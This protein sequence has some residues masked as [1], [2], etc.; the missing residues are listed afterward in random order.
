MKCSCD[1]FLM[2]SRKDKVAPSV[3]MSQRDSVRKRHREESTSTTDEGLSQR[4]RGNEENEPP[5]SHGPTAATCD[6]VKQSLTFGSTFDAVTPPGTSLLSLLPVLSKAWSSQAQCPDRGDQVL[7]LSTTSGRGNF[8]MSIDDIVSTQRET[9]VANAVSV[10]HS[11]PVEPH[12]DLGPPTNTDSSLMMLAADH[13]DQQCANPEDVVPTWFLDVSLIA[14]GLLRGD[15]GDC[16]IEVR[17]FGH[18][19]SMEPA[20]CH[21]IIDQLFDGTLSGEKLM[22][23]L[24]VFFLVRGCSLYEIHSMDS[25]KSRKQSK[26]VLPPLP[27]LAA[28]LSSDLVKKYIVNGSLLFDLL[29]AVL[30]AGCVAP[31]KV[32]DLG[33]VYALCCPRDAPFEQFP[34]T[35]QVMTSS[36]SDDVYG[37]IN[38]LVN[39]KVERWATSGNLDERRH[40]VVERCLRVTRSFYL[41]QLKD[42]VSTLRRFLPQRLLGPDHKLIDRSCEVPD[43]IELDNTMNVVCS[44]MK[45]HGLCVDLEQY[46]SFCSVLMAQCKALRSFVNKTVNVW[47]GND[48]SLVETSVMALCDVL[49]ERFGS[50]VV[51][52]ASWGAYQTKQGNSERFSKAQS[53]ALLEEVAMHVATR[54]IQVDSEPNDRFLEVAQVIFVF[55]IIEEIDAFRRRGDRFVARCSRDNRFACIPDQPPIFTVRP[56]WQHHVSGTGRVFSVGCNV[57]TLSRKDSAV[58]GWKHCPRNPLEKTPLLPGDVVAQL[59][60]TF[61]S[62]R[63]LVVAP[64]KCTFMS[65]D[66]CQIELRILA[67]LS[68]DERLR[69][70]FTV[71]PSSDVFIL[72][73]TTLV[74]WSSEFSFTFDINT[75]APS[76]R[77]ALR[78][79]AKTLVYSILFGRGAE[80]VARELQVSEASKYICLSADTSAA[81]PV[82]DSGSVALRIA[83]CIVTAFSRV[84][85]QA[86]DFLQSTMVTASTHWYVDGIYRRRMLARVPA[87]VLA[88]SGKKGEVERA[89]LSRA[90]QGSA[91]DIM[92]LA[93]WKIQRGCDALRSASLPAAAQQGPS[94]PDDADLA[95]PQHLRLVVTV[96]DELIFAVSSELNPEAMIDLQKWVVQQMLWAGEVLGMTNSSVPLRVTCRWRPSLCD[97][98]P[99]GTDGSHIE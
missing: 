29:H 6:T 49:R 52:D 95:S 31:R 28:L 1:F 41:G 90:I 5:L 92:K 13:E 11:I 97:E 26:D 20:R 38:K 3:T 42:E 53:L 62:L 63:R 88:S 58:L 43:V 96:H 75:A 57:Q 45:L 9:V 91:A 33:V 72:M 22:E 18:S 65:L 83:R 19:L 30:G 4:S 89:A 2:G 50:V 25:S 86:S 60:T 55:L 24:E 35:F 85:R 21:G 98:E 36:L 67:F 59:P 74:Q 80:A 39:T 32:V 64:P 46:E 16:T 23:E 76:E 79:I 54:F 34:L 48:G 82:V 7:P 44:M 94:T 77:K 73:M 15:V 81:I 61:L 40:A 14:S 68:G 71:D 93:V 78:S 66:Y 37:A 70:V 99:A 12:S 8:I 69:R 17:I 56:T 87:E 10:D 51:P 47:S 27:F 84:F